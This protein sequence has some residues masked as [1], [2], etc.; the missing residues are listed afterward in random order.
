[1]HMQDDIVNRVASSGLETFNLEDYYPEGKRVLLDIK[2]QLYQGMI[3]REKDFRT[4]LKENDWSIYEG[5]FVAITCSEDAIIPTWAYMLLSIKLKSAKKTVYGNLD[6]LEQVLYQ[7]ALSN[8]DFSKFEGKR[9]VIK[10]CSDRSISEQIYIEATQ[11][12]LPYAASIMF[13]E[14]CSTVPLFKKPKQ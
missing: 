8:I 1:M 7:E 3:L 2:D 11:R 12:L 5:K 13:G 10:G 14:P 6:D 4:F 9:V